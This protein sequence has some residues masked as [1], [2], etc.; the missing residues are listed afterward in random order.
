VGK[1][2]DMRLLL[3]CLLAVVLLLGACGEKAQEEAMEKKIEK[4]TGADAD[5]DLSEKS[6]KVAGKTDEGEF[7][8]EA[9]EEMEI[10][11]DFPADVFIYTPSKTVMAM[12]VPKGHSV[13]LLTE[14]DKTK[15]IDTYKREMESNGWTEETS[16]TMGD[17]MMLTYKKDARITGINFGTTDKGLQITVT[18]GEE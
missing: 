14:D 18:T 8:F 6:V 15:V 13:S 2:D 4:A 16:V 1:E 3:V 12:K 5:V 11:E 10:P 9:G 7:E 17:K